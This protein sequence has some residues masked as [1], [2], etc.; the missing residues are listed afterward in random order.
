MS[1]LA[2]PTLKTHP[3]TKLEPMRHGFIK[4]V[5]ALRSTDPE[6]FKNKKP[7][8][9]YRTFTGDGAAINFNTKLMNFMER[10]NH[11]S[12]RTRKNAK[13]K[14]TDTERVNIFSARIR[15]P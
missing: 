4:E 8:K 9:P 2:V 13:T 12:G 5:P 15:L 11:I 3:R 6:A 7:P 1:N 10:S 14:S